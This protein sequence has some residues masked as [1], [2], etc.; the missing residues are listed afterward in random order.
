MELERLGKYE[1]VERLGRGGMGEVWRAFDT[2]LRRHVAI[3]ILHADLQ[4]DPDFVT[5][6][7]REA[8]LVASLHHPNIVQIHDFQLVEG[9]GSSVKA[10]MVMDYI[11]G[12]TLADYI[13]ATVRKGIFPPA[14]D[15]VALFTAAGLAL[16]YAHQQG[17]IHRDIKPENILLDKSTGKVPGEPILTD[18]GIA[19]IQGTSESTLTR[20]WLGTPR[21]L[22][23]EQA[24]GRPVD[25]RADLYSLGIVLYEILTGITPFRGDNAY[26]IMMQHVHQQPP[27]PMLI[28][29]GITPALSAVV[30][31]SIAKDPAV[32][33]PSASAM[34]LALTN[35]FNPPAPASFSPTRSIGQNDGYNPLQPAIQPPGLD[36]RPP[37]GTATPQGP[38]SPVPGGYPQAQLISSPAIPPALDKAEMKEIHTP[39][40]LPPKRPRRRNLY[41]V[42]AACVLLALGISSFFAFPLLF[43]QHSGQGTPTPGAAGDVVGTLVFQHSSNAAANVFD[44]VQVKIDHIASPPAGTTYY[45]W[46]ESPGNDLSVSPHWQLPVSNGS[47]NY[48]YSGSPQHDLYASSTIFL[49]TTETVSSPPIPNPTGRLYHATITHTSATPPTFEIK[50]CS[51]SGVNGC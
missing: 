39:A 33:F 2:G 3:K 28:N 46:L 50:K 22:S 17:M 51:Q 6:F 14:D 9:E 34:A 10:F 44:Q 31:Q 37:V 21:Y 40:A 47:V 15:I 48:L 36:A 13:A 20:S 1:L 29:P 35:A 49:I 38:Y 42:I 45:A 12:G 18:F 41:I 8:Q 11:E 32:R 26:A 43:S 27:P 23:P 25:K 24:E 19:R 16:D 7:M 4:A 5:H 30:L